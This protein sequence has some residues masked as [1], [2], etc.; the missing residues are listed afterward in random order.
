MR[1]ERGINPNCSEATIRFN[2]KKLTQK[3]EEK[4]YKALEAYIKEYSYETYVSRNNI[5]N[6]PCITVQGDA[7]YN[8]GD[9]LMG[10]VNDLPFKNKITIS[11]E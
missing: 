1:I 8:D 10:I 4:L 2:T 9:K 7:P 11:E 5:F 3:E 6:I